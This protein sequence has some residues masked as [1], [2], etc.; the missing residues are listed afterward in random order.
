VSNTILDKYTTRYNQVLV[1]ISINLEKYLKSIFSMPNID[2]ISVRPKDISSFIIKSEKI[3]NGILKYDEP[4]EQIQDQLGARIVTNF[5]LDVRIISK[6]VENYFSKIE[7][8]KVISDDPATFGYQ[9]LHYLLLIPEDIFTVSINRELCP[10]FFELQ[11]CTLFQHAW[12]EANH[13]LGYKPESDL[14]DDD[15]RKLAFTAAQAWG[16]D[17]IFDDLSKKKTT[18]QN[19]I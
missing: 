3:Q 7:K 6:H 17:M 13:N 18:N 11:I 9:S 19:Y 1:P 4:L 10:N 2:F 5:N 16:A 14:S 8:T 12:A 15:K